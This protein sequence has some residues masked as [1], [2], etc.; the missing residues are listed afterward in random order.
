M[1]PEQ[2]PQLQQAVKAA[3]DCIALGISF[4]DTTDTPK[5]T[6]FR[7]AVKLFVLTEKVIGVSL[8]IPNPLNG[9]YVMHALIH[10]VNSHRQY[11]LVNISRKVFI[12]I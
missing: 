8:N 4:H 2:R 9:N 6:P 10:T 1:F 11:P 3:A 12:Y 7:N 5:F